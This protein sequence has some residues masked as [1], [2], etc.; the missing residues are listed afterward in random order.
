MIDQAAGRGDENLGVAAEQFHLLR[1]RHAAEDGDGL[2]VADVSGVLVGRRGD[3]Q[4]EFARRREYQHLRL[5]RLEARAFAATGTRRLTFLVRGAARSGRRGDERRA[6][7][8]RQA[9]QCRQHEGGSF[10]GS[11][12]RG[13]KQVAAFDGGGNRLGLDGGR[14]GVTGLGKGFKQGFVKPD[15]CKGHQFLSCRT[16]PHN[17]G[18]PMR[19]RKNATPTNESVERLCL[20]ER[21]RDISAQ[22]AL[23]QGG[24]YGSTPGGRGAW[25]MRRGSRSE[26]SLQFSA[27]DSLE[28]HEARILL[29]GLT[30]VERFLVVFC[31]SRSRRAKTPTWRVMAKRPR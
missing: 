27:I 16:A 18:E 17:R 3:L 5:C 9:V 7:L 26:K 20:G 4:G 6:F 11:G 13:N 12:L 30:R 10:S 2:Q 21:I 1:I 14:V 22:Q 25:E 8:R 31:D 28:L 19:G 29:A 15:F 23:C 24:V